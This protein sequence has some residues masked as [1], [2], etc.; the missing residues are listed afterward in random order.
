MTAM[1]LSASA[2]TDALLA[3]EQRVG[4]DDPA[5]TD[6]DVH[7]WPLYRTEIY[8]LLFAADAGTV[9]SAKNSSRVGPALRCSTH[10][11]KPGA[12]GAVWLVSD[13]LSYAKVN[14]EREIERFCGPLWQRCTAANIPAVVIDRASPVRRTTQ[15]PSRWWAPWTQRAKII[16]TVSARLALLPRHADLV[17]KVHQAATTLG[18]S[19]LKMCGYRMQAMSSAT[20]RLARLIE[21]RLRLERVRAVFVVSFYDVAG[22]AYCLAAARAGVMSIDV[23]H[24]VTGRYHMAY[25]QWPATHTPWRLLPRWFWTWT[26]A[27]AALIENWAGPRRAV[28][29]GHPYLDA[30][31][32]GSLSLDATLKR[33]LQA[34][35]ERTGERTPVLVTLQPN[36]VHEQ[37]LAPLLW[38]MARRKNTFWWLRLH[39]I[40]LND[41]AALE[42]LLAFKGIDGFDIETATVLP[43]PVVLGHARLHATHSSS[44]F[45]EAAALGIPSIVWSAYGAELAEDAIAEGSTHPAFDGPSLAALVESGITADTSAASLTARGP[46]ALRTILES[47]PS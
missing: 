34:L 6:G 8:R 15:E 5:W 9:P 26:K 41:R 44:A 22:Y 31:R 45:I 2:I 20:I 1:P 32:D 18:L 37:A 40:G 28:C 42:A 30:W 27:D 17:E 14:G 16:G 13:G 12:S 4:L 47:C 25:S 21:H 39:P 11:P 35:R 3:L 7:W 46:D 38:A 19:Q 43:L 24:G 23:Q 36:L 33:S 10:G 29:G